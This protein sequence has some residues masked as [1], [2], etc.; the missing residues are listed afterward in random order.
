MQS[1]S[2]ITCLSLITYTCFYISNDIK[3]VF[4]NPRLSAA[5]DVLGQRIGCGRPLDNGTVKVKAILSIFLY[6]YYVITIFHGDDLVKN[7]EAF[8]SSFAPLSPSQVLHLDSKNIDL[9]QINNFLQGGSLFS[10]GLAIAIDN[11][12]SI[13]KST[14]TKLTDLFV[15]TKASIFLWQDKLLTVAQ[16]KI[17]PKAIVNRFKIDNH[18]FPCINSI[19]PK[20]LPKFVPFYHQIC[21]HDLFDLFF[22]LLKASFRKQIQ[23]KSIY[24]QSILI[25]TYLQMIE[26][27]YQYKTGQLSLPKEIALE[28]V[29][30]PLLK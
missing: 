2:Q 3:E 5:A 10:D 8:L 18:I 13:T 22:Y 26:L 24:P 15:K 12:F 27:E 25:K 29:L 17:F 1:S 9:N 6:N 28:R 19:K 30:L 23:T 4:H 14:Q 16:L 21:S 7:R 20:N 11:F